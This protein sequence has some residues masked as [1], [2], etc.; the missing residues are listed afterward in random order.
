MKEGMLFHAIDAK[1]S[2]RKL[3]FDDRKLISAALGPGGR[4]ETQRTI[5]W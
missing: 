2:T 3:T 5:W 1:I 4:L